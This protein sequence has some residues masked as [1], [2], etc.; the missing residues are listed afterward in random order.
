M[1]IAIS[2]TPGTGKHSIAERISKLTGYKIIDLGKMLSSKNGEKEISIKELNKSFQKVKSDNSLVISHLSHLLN[3]KSIK[4]TI[5][6]RTDPFI[7]KKRLEKRGYAKSKVYDNVMFEALDGT[8]IEA[9]K[10]KR[11]VFQVDNSKDIEIAVKKVLNIIH[12]KGK[13]DNV[14]FSDRIIKIE[15]MFK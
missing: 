6:I 10:R 4:T 15:E 9:K 7:L 8:Y 2:G 14:N 5:I 13:D 12:G 11:K 1:I 3:S